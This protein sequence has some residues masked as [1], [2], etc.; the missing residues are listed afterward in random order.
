MDS[1][2]SWSL[3]KTK[4]IYIQVLILCYPNPNKRYTVYT[5]ASDDTCGAQLSHEHNVTEF[6]IAFLLHTFSETQRKW[7]MTEQEAYGIYY[8][9]T[10]WDYYLQG[11]DIMVRNYHKPLTKF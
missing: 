11:A 8:A 4:R 10:K 1:N 6:P 9:I 3:P 7:S 5:D 2:T